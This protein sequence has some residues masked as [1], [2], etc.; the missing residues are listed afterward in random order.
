MNWYEKSKILGRFRNLNNAE[1]IRIYEFRDNP[2]PAEAALWDIVKN[3]QLN[4]FKFRRQHKIGQFVVDF[5]CHKAGLVI[6]VD[7]AVH[8]E[9]RGEDRIRTEWLMTLGLQI[10]RFRNE[11]ILENPVSVKEEILKIL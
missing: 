7:G 4:G 11:E 3:K 1:K 5:Y 2:T 9:K 10:V 6:E 8:R